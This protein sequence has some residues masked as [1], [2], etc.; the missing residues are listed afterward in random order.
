MDSTSR[1]IL[2]A[3]DSER[4][5]STAL[6]LAQHLGLRLADVEQ[7][8]KTLTAR[9]FVHRITSIGRHPARYLLSPRG[10]E[11]ARGE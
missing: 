7:S 9:R 3:L 1:A 2:E 4:G 10:R 5:S 8:L 11:A 6:E